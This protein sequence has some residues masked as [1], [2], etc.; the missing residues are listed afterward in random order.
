MRQTIT[1]HPDPSRPREKPETH[2]TGNTTLAQ[3]LSHQAIFEIRKASAL[4]EM[5]FRQKQ[6]PQPQILRPG[7]Q[8]IDDSRVALPSLSPLA[9]LSE[10]DSVGWDAF[11]LDEFLDLSGI[12]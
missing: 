12:S 10:I 6:I 4:P 3:P 8:I 9:Q 2:L 11:F 1:S 7:L 5:A